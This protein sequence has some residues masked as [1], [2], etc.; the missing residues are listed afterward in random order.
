[1]LDVS[2]ARRPRR[3]LPA[4]AAPGENLGEDIAKGRTKACRT[5]FLGGEIREVE[6]GEI[7]TRTAFGVL[8]GASRISFVSAGWNAVGVE[9]ILI[10][11][12]PLFFVAEDVVRFLD[13]LEFFFRL[14]IA[15]VD[16]RM[17]LPGKPTVGFSDLVRLGGAIDSQIA[18]I[19]LLLDSRRHAHSPLVKLPRHAAD[20]DS[21]FS[22]EGGC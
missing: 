8:H 15:R 22:V 2:P 16:I 13:F 14:L 5:L 12:L 6:A 18:V 1:M 10:V 11:N 20:C 7:N 19:I 17:V 3:I 4:F 21:S 9:S